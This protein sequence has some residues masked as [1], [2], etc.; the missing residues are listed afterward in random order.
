MYELFV[1]LSESTTPQE[2]L[3][4]HIDAFKCEIDIVD[5]FKYAELCEEFG[6]AYSHS[7]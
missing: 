3:T 4:V 1:N 2:C 7:I 5:A 6:R